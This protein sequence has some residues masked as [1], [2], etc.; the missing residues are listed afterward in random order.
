MAQ[1]IGKQK[2]RHVFPEQAWS[3]LFLGGFSIL[4]T[5]VLAGYFRRAH[6]PGILAVL[7]IVLALTTILVYPVILRESRI[8][9]WLSSFACTMTTQPTPTVTSADVERI[10]Q[11][12]FPADRVPEVLGI[13]DEYGKEALDR[14]AH[15][16]RIAVLK[17]AAGN[18]KRLRCEIEDAKRD[19]R[20]VLAAAEYPGYFRR[21]P[22]PGQL[23]PVQE[24]QIIDADWK[25]YQDW[26]IR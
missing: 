15:R 11:R 19:Y 24:Q 9:R 17:L 2:T 1:I 7:L 16:V 21:V 13:L 8:E 22:G 5:F 10:V 6:V 3:Y 18:L 14:E 20:D 25:Q 4:L 26:F 12:D 23:P